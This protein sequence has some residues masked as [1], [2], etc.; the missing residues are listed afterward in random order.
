[1]GA[2]AAEDA[3]SM[4]GRRGHCELI[5]AKPCTV[6]DVAEVSESD[7]LGYEKIQYP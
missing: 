7:F 3:E 2:E 1:M 4:S 5:T 6:S